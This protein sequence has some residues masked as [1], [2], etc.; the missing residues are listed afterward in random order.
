[1]QRVSLHEAQHLEKIRDC[2][3]NLSPRLEMDEELRVAA[4]APLERM[5]L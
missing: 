5:M 4:L 1:M 2:L 3:A